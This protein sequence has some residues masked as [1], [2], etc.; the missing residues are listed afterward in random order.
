[1]WLAAVAPAALA[2]EVSGPVDPW[3]YSYCG[4]QPVYPV[5]GYTFATVCGPRNQIA[6]GRRGHLMW[7]FPNEND[8]ASGRRGTRKLGTK[9]LKR[10]SLLAEVAQLAD[11]PP[12]G[13]AAVVYNL[14][15]DFQGRSYKR[16]HAPLGEQYAP[17]HEL[18]RAMLALVPDAPLLP[19]CGGAL[20]DF[21][22]TLM[23]AERVTTVLPAGKS[24][25]EKN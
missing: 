3:D 10:L 5:I 4:G 11:P 25:H 14:G 15:I 8:P 2:S 12:S 6:L 18:F 1:M 16:V 19:A 20:R 17:A 7:S 24:G 23:P 13:A 9:E 21:N 22:P